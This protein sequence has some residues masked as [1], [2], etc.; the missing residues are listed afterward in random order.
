MDLPS[1]SMAGRSRYF[2]S[3]ER[4][5]QRKSRRM[6][7]RTDLEKEMERKK[8]IRARENCAK[9]EETEE[10]RD[11]GKEDHDLLVWGVLSVLHSS[12]EVTR[13]AF[14]WSFAMR[15]SRSTT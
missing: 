13:I 9:G 12:L 1:F 15:S 4:M 7:Y 2:F 10:K 3:L 8:S 14:E 5:W 11:R 6:G